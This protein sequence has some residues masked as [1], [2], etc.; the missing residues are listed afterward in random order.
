MEILDLNVRNKKKL[1]IGCGVHPREGYIHL[2][3]Q[4]LPHIEYVCDARKLPF[5]DNELDD[6]YSSNTLEHFG[7]REVGNVLKHWASKLK[8]CGE[9][10]LKVPCQK[11]VS[12]AY[13][14]GRMN[15]K[16]F[17]NA[18]YADQDDYTNYHKC[19]FDPTWLT[20][21]LQEAGFAH[22]KVMEEYKDTYGEL[23]G[24]LIKAVKI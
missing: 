12:R 22:I 2:D 24:F 15:A 18:T 21:L 10:E 7:W 14:E 17:S 9:I 13:Y 4:K 5:E 19:A 11:S 23:T 8:R 6:I 20:E 1:D 16:E 3:I